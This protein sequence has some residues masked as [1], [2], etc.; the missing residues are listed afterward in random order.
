MTDEWN[1]MREC[2]SSLPGCIAL[3]LDSCDE[4][5]K[6]FNSIFDEIQEVLKSEGKSHVRTNLNQD[7]RMVTLQYFSI[8]YIVAYRAASDRDDL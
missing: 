2:D 5:L 4:E 6:Y 1:Q 8:I 7:L 3:T